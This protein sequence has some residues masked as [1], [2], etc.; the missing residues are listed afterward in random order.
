MTYREVQATGAKV[1]GTPSW[2]PKED[3]SE[4]SL[5]RLWQMRLQNH[6]MLALSAER[7]TFGGWNERS[8]AE[9]IERAD[10]GERVFCVAFDEAEGQFLFAATIAHGR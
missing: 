8:L 7:R 5:D 2:I 3:W 1:F 4:V 9:A 10:R 6:D